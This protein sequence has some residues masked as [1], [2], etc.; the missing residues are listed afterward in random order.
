MV[1]KQKVKGSAWERLLVNILLDKIDG[2]V[3]K[4][5]AGSGAIGTTLNEPLLQ[6][7]VI[8]SFKG[9][10][11]KFRIE[12]KTGYGGATQLTIKREWLDKIRGEALSSNAYPALACKFSGARP[13]GVQ[14]FVALD[15]DTF[16]DIMNYINNL[17]KEN[18]ILVS[19]VSDGKI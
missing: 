15:I 9:L 4:R 14:F 16:I 11:K 2:S 19:R 8:A 1:N 17:K 3:V 13:G 5:I 7:D 18:D 6:G 12:A 10:D